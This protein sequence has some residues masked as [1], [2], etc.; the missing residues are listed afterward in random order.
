MQIARWNQLKDHLINERQRLSC[1]PLLR[2]LSDRS[3]AKHPPCHRFGLSK[4]S[5]NLRQQDLGYF[6]C[7][8][9]PEIRHKIAQFFVNYSYHSFLGM[10]PFDMNHQKRCH[11]QLELGMASECSIWSDGVAQTS[12]TCPLF[13]TTITP[14]LTR[15]DLSIR[16]AKPRGTAF[17]KPRNVDLTASLSTRCRSHLRTGPLQNYGA[18]IFKHNSTYLIYSSKPIEANK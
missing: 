7:L 2:S 13:S 3:V 16:L 9:I 6:T 1:V 15:H 12:E 8:Q 10:S 11:N 4:L 17:E 18:S 5:A 14:V